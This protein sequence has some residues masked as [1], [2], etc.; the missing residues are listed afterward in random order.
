M[1]MKKILA[2][3][4]GVSERKPQGVDDMKRFVSIIKESTAPVKET[5]IT[6]FEEGSVGGAVG[7]VG[8]VDSS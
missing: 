5:V 8:S 4:D 1:D 2:A 7:S 6:G 3:L